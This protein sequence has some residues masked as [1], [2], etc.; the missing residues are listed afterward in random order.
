MPDP[1][2]LAFENFLDEAL[3]QTKSHFGLI[4]DGIE[5]T[6]S[7]QYYRAADHLT[8]AADR[9]PDNSIPLLAGKSALVRVYLR[10]HRGPLAGAT[11]TLSVERLNWVMLP[12]LLATLATPATRNHH[13]A[14]R[15]PLRRGTRRSVCVA[16]LPHS[17]RAGRPPSPADGA[18]ALGGRL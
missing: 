8:D 4:V 1:L 18:G 2:K 7:T 3:K 14:G 15:S 5:V 13:G 17:G 9:G 12:T 16:Q 6:Q 11:G 10:N